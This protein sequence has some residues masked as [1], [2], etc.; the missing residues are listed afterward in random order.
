MT[1]RLGNSVD[2]QVPQRNAGAQG[3]AQPAPSLPSPKPTPEVN[4]GTLPADRSPINPTNV[5]GT[6]PTDP[7][8]SPFHNP[9]G[10]HPATTDINGGQGDEGVIHTPGKKPSSNRL[11]R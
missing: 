6:V 4:P 9:Q 10:T 2:A 8:P 7:S 1:V 3:G 11:N 5:T